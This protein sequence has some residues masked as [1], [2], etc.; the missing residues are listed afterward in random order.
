MEAVASGTGASIGVAAVARRWFRRAVQDVVD[1]S[2]ADVLRR[3]REFERR[4]GAHL[5]QQDVRL[6]R[7]EAKLDRRWR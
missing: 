5:D 1:E 7:I 2:V 3:Q 4:Q 6:T